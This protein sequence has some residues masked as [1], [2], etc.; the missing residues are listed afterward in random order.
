M[1]PTLHKHIKKIIHLIFPLYM[2][3]AILYYVM[4]IIILG[5]VYY[6]YYDFHYCYFHFTESK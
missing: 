4:P 6:Y 3:D 1:S 2:M 5:R